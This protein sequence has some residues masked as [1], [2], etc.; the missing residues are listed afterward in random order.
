MHAIIAVGIGGF[1]GAIGRTF[2]ALLIVNTVDSIIPWATF[3]ANILGSFGLALVFTLFGKKITLN[4]KIKIGLTTGFFGSF[5]TFSTISLEA[6]NLLDQYGIFWW[7][8]YES[9]T[10]FGGIMAALG[11]WW[12][13]KY[14]EQFAGVENPQQH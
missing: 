7:L 10:V 3:T 1:C 6:I 14:L 13:A 4:P 8:G 9:L 2:L 5:T 12:L 11:G